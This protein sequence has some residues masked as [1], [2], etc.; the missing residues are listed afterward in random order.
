MSTLA[1]RVIAGWISA[2]CRDSTTGPTAPIDELSERRSIP[3]TTGLADP[4]AH[5]PPSKGASWSWT[6]AVLS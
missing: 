1:A 6:W 4:P 3:V 2:C 5:T